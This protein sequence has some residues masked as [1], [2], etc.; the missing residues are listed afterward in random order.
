GALARG[1]A[2]R[3]RS[4]AAGLHR[5]QV[6]APRIRRPVTRRGRAWRRAFRRARVRPSHCQAAGRSAAGAGARGP[7]RVLPTASPRG[8]AGHGSYRTVA[9]AKPDRRRAGRDA[10]RGGFSD[11]RLDRER[12]RRRAAPPVAPC[13][14]T[15]HQRA[16][17]LPAS[18][19]GGGRSMSAA[20]IA[21]IGAGT[22]GHG[23]A[24][25]AALAGFDVCLTDSQPDALRRGM[26]RLNDL[27]AIAVRRGKLTE[28][29]RDAAAGRL[30]AE[31]DF[32]PAVLD[33]EVVIEAVREHLGTKQQ[34]FAEIDR[35]AP[36]DA[37]LATN[38]SSLSVA[39]IAAAARDPARVVGLH[40]FNPVHAMKLVEVV[41]HPQATSP[42][43]ERAVAFAK[44]LGKEPIVVKDSPG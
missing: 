12:P 27:L 31:S 26:G 11:L 3:H 25:V 23:I 5:G 35:A 20:R 21:V 18:H 28:Q 41:T 30:H 8:V 10:P 19:G 6:P 37:L 42:S 34:V 9:G 33:A 16:G 29:D 4:G 14:R 15:V 43:V 17:R 22:M 13:G 1:C 38:T 7:A 36:A 32:A 2:G 24:Y 40:F 44:A 39:A